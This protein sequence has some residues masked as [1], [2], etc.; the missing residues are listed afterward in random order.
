MD[1]FSDSRYGDLIPSRQKSPHLSG[2]LQWAVVVLWKAQHYEARHQLLTHFPSLKLY[3]PIHWAHTCLVTADS[4]D[5]LRS[6]SWNPKGTSRRMSPC[7]PTATVP[8][9]DEKK[10]CSVP[11]FV[12]YFSFAEYSMMTLA[13]TL[14]CFWVKFP[15]FSRL[16]NVYFKDNFKCRFSLLETETR[17]ANPFITVLWLFQSI[18]QSTLIRS[19]ERRQGLEKCVSMKSFFMIFLL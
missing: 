7:C 8:H 11:P 14:L 1:L 5:S 4:V 13:E 10:L 19:N 2:Y 9:K 6:R 3:C 16:L 15:L 17:H 12:P 18:S